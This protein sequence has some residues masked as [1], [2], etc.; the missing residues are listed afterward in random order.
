VTVE[1]GGETHSTYL[2]VIDPAGDVR[3]TF[4][5]DTEPRDI[6]RDVDLL[7]KGK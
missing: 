1:A 6:A 5:P 4:L 3:E 2:Y 7:L